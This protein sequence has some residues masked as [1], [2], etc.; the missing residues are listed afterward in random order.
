MIGWFFPTSCRYDSVEKAGDGKGKG[1]GK[2]R[3]VVIVIEVYFA[4]ALSGH[5]HRMGAVTRHVHVFLSAAVLPSPMC[6]TVRACGIGAV[7]WPVYLG[8]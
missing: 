3:S 1:K 4:C 5:L 7:L 2:G 8:L 6:S